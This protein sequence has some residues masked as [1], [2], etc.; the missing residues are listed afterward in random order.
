MQHEKS[1]SSSIE[2]ILNTATKQAQRGESKGR[3]SD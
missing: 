2:R 1:F 3:S